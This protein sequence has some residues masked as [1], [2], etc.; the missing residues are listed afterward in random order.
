[1]N[2]TEDEALRRLTSLCA[3]RELCS[4]DIRKKMRLWGLYPEAQDRVLA[5]L[6]DNRFVDDLRYAR[7]FVDEKIRLYKWGPRKIEH[8][9]L[10]KGVDNT[11]IRTALEEVDT[12]TF[13]EALRHLLDSKRYTIHPADPQTRAKLVRFALARGFDMETISR[14]L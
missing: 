14:C 9:L 6:V 7:A 2:K 11:T 8:A 1:M 13:V 3:R 12:E 4:P 5:Y 10:T